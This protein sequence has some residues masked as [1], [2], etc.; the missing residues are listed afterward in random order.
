[1]LRRLV[2]M[3]KDR[4]VVDHDVKKSYLCDQDCMACQVVRRMVFEGE[5]YSSDVISDFAGQ[6]ET[7]PWTTLATPNCKWHV[8]ALYTDLVDVVERYPTLVLRA[9]E[10]MSELIRNPEVQ[11][12]QHHPIRV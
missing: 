11:P 1:M 12:L 3:V 7:K 4:F 8:L 6:G 9:R 10:V 2:G 5:S